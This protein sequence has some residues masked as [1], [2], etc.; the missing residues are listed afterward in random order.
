MWFQ[1]D[2]TLGYPHWYRRDVLGTPLRIAIEV[3]RLIS[4]TAAAK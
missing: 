3:N 4:I 2:A 1:P